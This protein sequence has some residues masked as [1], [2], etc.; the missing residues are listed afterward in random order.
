MINSIKNDK[1]QISVASKGAELVSL[2]TVADDCEF[3]WQG[4]PAFWSGQA[5]ILFPII[6]GLVDDQYELDGRI[7]QM[8]HHGFARKSDFE[9]SDK[10]ESHLEY[11]MGFSEETLRHYPYQFEFAVSYRLEGNSLIHGFAVKNLDQREM[12]FSVGAHPGF[13]CPF[14]KGEAI[15]DYYLRFEKPERLQRRIKEAGLL[16][17]EKIGFLD[18]A[19]EKTLGHDWF[20]RGAVI[21]DAVQSDWLEI[22]SVKN[23]RVIR[24][25]F[26]GFP[27]LGIWSAAPRAPFVCIEPWFGL[28]SSRGDAPDLRRKEGLQ[29]LAPGSVFRSEY[30]IIICAR[31]TSPSASDNG[32]R[33]NKTR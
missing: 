32:G 20:A 19:V 24:I 31:D 25:T 18:G 5:P 6:G 28:D 2:K 16:S 1:L 29:R 30:F 17:G 12:L 7:Y 22:R 11:K 21:L 15:E 9:L 33:Q 8:E 14:N 3:L 13:N 4:D 27:Y 23:D 26:A 10:S